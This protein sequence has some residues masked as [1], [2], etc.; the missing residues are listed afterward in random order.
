MRPPVLFQA[1]V[2]MVVSGLRGWGW[3]SAGHVGCYTA[4]KDVSGY[5]GE[6]GANWRCPCLPSGTTSLRHTE[7]VTRG[8]SE[9]VNRRCSRC[10]YNVICEDVGVRPTHAHTK[11]KLWLGFVCCSHH[12][13]FH[14]HRS[15]LPPTHTP[16]PPTPSQPD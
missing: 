5:T 2:R 12:L 14:A 9:P 10:F 8:P 3:K 4:V 16:H 11:W 15:D 13:Q 7:R 6:S 1:P